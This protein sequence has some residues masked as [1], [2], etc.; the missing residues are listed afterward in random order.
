MTAVLQAKSIAA[1]YRDR[2]VLESIDLSIQEGGVTA[3]IGPNGSGKS[4]LLKTF[5]RLLAP[6]GGSILLDGR[7]I[8]EQKSSEIARRIAV[9]PQ[10]P[11]APENLT[12]RELVEQ[13]RYPHLGALRMLRSGDHD[14]VREALRLTGMEGFAHRP[15]DALSGGERQRA[16][17]ALTLAQGSPVLLLD[18]PTTFLDIGHQLEVLDLVQSLNRDRGMTVIMVLHDLNQA[19][20]YADRMVVLSQGGIFAD[21]LPSDVF[22]PAML[23]DVFGIE[24]SVTI[25]PNTGTSHCVPLRA[26]PK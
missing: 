26:L 4:T 14:E 23:A 5:A 25:D 22:T 24:A 1:G 11:I 19:A 7:A 3:L 8:R 15:V 12:V 18:E 9:L 16:W 2:P 17:I 10:Q 20:K 21:G 13:G 6:R